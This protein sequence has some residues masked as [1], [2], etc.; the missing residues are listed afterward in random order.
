MPVQGGFVLTTT[1][2]EEGK[3]NSSVAGV[4]FL[5]DSGETEQ[6]L[7]GF[8]S[9]VAASPDGCHVA[10]GIQQGNLDLHPMIGDYYISKPRLEVLD[11]CAGILGL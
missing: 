7:A 2:R 5:K 11:V 9:A 10:V 8:V 3:K 4:Y 1:E 6:L